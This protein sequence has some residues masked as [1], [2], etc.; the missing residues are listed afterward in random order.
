[1]VSS[2]LDKYMVS[3]CVGL[4]SSIENWVVRSA[5][6]F[7]LKGQ[8]AVFVSFLSFQNFGRLYQT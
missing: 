8:K 1:M 4:S 6:V 2:S 3:V 7:F 5:M